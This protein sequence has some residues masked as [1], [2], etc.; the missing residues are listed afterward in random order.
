MTVLKEENES[1]A[2]DKKSIAVAPAVAKVCSG[3]YGC[4]SALTMHVRD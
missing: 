1:I 3:H 4:V 2:F